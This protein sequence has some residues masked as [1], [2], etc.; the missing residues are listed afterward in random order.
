MSGDLT[1]V[2]MRLED[3]IFQIIASFRILH[4]KLALTVVRIMLEGK[5]FKI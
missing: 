3:K 5:V 2:R 1:V 4:S